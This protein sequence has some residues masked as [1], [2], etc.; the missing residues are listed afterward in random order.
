M[1][2]MSLNFQ[3]VNRILFSLTLSVVMSCLLCCSWSTKNAFS[4]V[5]DF[6]FVS[7]KKTLSGIID[8]PISGEA[9][10]LIILVHGSGATDIRRENRYFGL[11]NRFTELG[12]TCVTWDKPGMGRSQGN[13]DA[14]QPPEESAQEILDAVAYLQ[15]AKVH[16]SNKIGIWSISSGGW[17]APIAISKDTSIKFWISVS[18]VPPEDNKYYLMESNLPLEGRTPKE[19]KLL[20]E[21]LKHGRQILIQGGKY[22]SYLAATENLRKD[23]SVFY[24]AG[25]LTGSEE[26][27][28]AEQK[29]YL[30]AEHKY[31]FDENISVIRVPNFDRTLS[32]LG[33]NVLALFGEKDTNVNWRKTLALYKSA[34]GQNPQAT[35]TVHTFPNANHNINVSKTGSVREVEGMPVGAGVISKGY[36]ETQIK[37]L[38]KY[39]IPE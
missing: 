38:M 32:K 37:W 14:N 36:Y 11:R 23:T 29:A 35:L 8:Q 12:I 34:I 10:A 9:K 25:D 24:F 16:G 31:E 30:N 13:F 21:E 7:E 39:V 22:D 33:I 3:K 18:G 15:K 27:F 17:T 26:Q 6:E 28:E 5:T 19:T 1:K 4:T 2:I 20:M